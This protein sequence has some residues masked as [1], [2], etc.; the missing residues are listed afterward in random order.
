MFSPWTFWVLFWT[1]TSAPVDVPV[2]SGAVTVCIF[3]ARAG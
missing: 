1:E 2:R 3:R